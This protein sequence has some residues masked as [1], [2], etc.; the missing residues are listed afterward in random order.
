M[1]QVIQ[2]GAAQ[3]H[4]PQEVLPR[5][6]NQTPSVEGKAYGKQRVDGKSRADVGS[7]GPRCGG[8]EE[9]CRNPRTL[10]GQPGGSL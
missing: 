3:R 1:P 9:A 6:K 10:T 5:K 4:L 8:G 2:A 7:G